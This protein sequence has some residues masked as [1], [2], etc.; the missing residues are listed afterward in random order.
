[1]STGYGVALSVTTLTLLALVS[2]LFAAETADSNYAMPQAVLTQA[3]GEETVVVL[4]SVG[5]GTTNPPAGNYTLPNQAAFTLTALPADGYHLQFWVINNYVP[6]QGTATPNSGYNTTTTTS[7]P[8]TIQGK[9][10]YTYYVQA[11]FQ[12]DNETTDP[13]SLGWN[14]TVAMTFL[15][16]VAVTEAFFLGYLFVKKVKPNWKG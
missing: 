11:M 12:P 1:M 8:L 13:L 5:Q 4:S 7:N 6:P 3:S 10:G 2:A 16:G 9:N 15:A 14:V